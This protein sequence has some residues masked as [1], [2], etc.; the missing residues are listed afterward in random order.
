[1]ADPVLLPMPSGASGTVSP[2]DD[3]VVDRAGRPI[4]LSGFVWSLADPTRSQ[5]LDWREVVIPN[6]SVWAAT[7]AYIKHLIRSYSVGEIIG[8]WYALAK[9][10]A[11]PSFQA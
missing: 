5:T 8:N 7:R 4:D 9:V 1:M 10:W 11:S 2:E 3:V 6:K